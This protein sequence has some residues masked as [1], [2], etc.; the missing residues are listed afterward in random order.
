[1]KNS[2]FG[3]SSFFAKANQECK[4]EKERNLTWRNS[5]GPQLLN[6]FRVLLGVYFMH[7]ICLFQSSGSYESN[8]SNGARIG[9]ETKKLWPFEDNHIKL[10]EISQPKAH[11]AV[12]KW[13]A[14]PTFGTW[15]PFSSLC[16]LLHSCEPRCKIT[17]K[18]WMKLQI[19]SK[20]QNHLQVVKS[21][22]TCK[23]KVQTWKMDNSTCEIH[24]CN[25]RYLLS[26]KLDFF[27]RYFV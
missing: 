6:T 23:I 11:F 2:S 10:C 1:M 3:A 17:S 13:A 20:L 14:K 4:E 12:V 7:T 19:I 8:A 25:L 21:H 15:V 27:S 18:L 9:I 26:T 22:S 24:L 5:I 16:L